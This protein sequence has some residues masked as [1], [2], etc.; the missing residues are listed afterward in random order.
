MKTISEAL[1]SLYKPVKCHPNWADK[2]ALSINSQKNHYSFTQLEEDISTFAK[3]LLA[4]GLNNQDKVVISSPNSPSYVALLLAIWRV[5][6][7]AVPIDFR[8]TQGEIINVISALEARIFISTH[9]TLES[10]KQANNKLAN[11]KLTILDFEGLKNK[12][13]SEKEILADDAFEDIDRSALIIMTSG[14]TGKPKGAVHNLSSLITNF[15]ELGILVGVEPGTKFL[16]PLPLSHIFGLTTCLV[17]LMHGASIYFAL[18]PEEFIRSLS[19]SPSYDIVAGV[20]ALYSAMLC[21]SAEGLKLAECRI[22][23]SGGSPLPESLAEEFRAKF[24]KRLN[25]GYG[26]TESKIVALNLTGPDLSVGPL[27]PSA[28]VIIFDSDHKL[29]KE[30]EIGEICLSGSMLMQGYFDQSAETEMVLHDGHYHT[31]DLGYL[32]DSYL[33]ISG[34]E[35]ELINVAGNKVFPS[36]VEDVLRQHENVQ[37][38]AILG[39]PHSRLGQLVKAIIVVKDATISDQLSGNS[40]SKREARQKLLNSFKEYCKANLKKEMRPLEWV[41]WENK[42]N[43]P[44]TNTGK[45][46][47]QKLQ[48][49]L[50]TPK[51][52]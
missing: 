8:M 4:S 52:I 6:A 37:E 19:D 51:T 5:G 27:I 10:I 21:Q 46:D 49:L 32:K 25:N 2:T 20:P 12:G 45:V 38:V 39:V 3:G 35:K 43:L 13:I 30:G 1:G 36:E 33:Y 31:G 11:V 16:L 17:A 15:I 47:K 14:T 18:T 28:K 9:T 7:I 42:K 40:D 23:L 22:L 26:S 24:A 34:R 41:F 50:S 44:K 48:E 29:L